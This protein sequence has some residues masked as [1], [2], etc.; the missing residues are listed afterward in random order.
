M[1]KK[2]EGMYWVYLLRCGD[3][4]LYAGITTDPAR[5][6][7]QH[8]GELPGGAKYTA[9]HIPVG[10]ARLWRAPDRSAASKTERALKSLSHA[11]KEALAAG[12]D[13]PGP[14]PEGVVPEA[15]E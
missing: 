11:Q 7:R 9:A 10:Y 13:F 8:R 6:L 4:S 15:G 12:G 5:R 3:G 14:L 1:N 2:G